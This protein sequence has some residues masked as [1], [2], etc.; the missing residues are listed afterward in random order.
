MEIK[1][2]TDD[3]KIKV[4]KCSKMSLSSLSSSEEQAAA[5]EEI[6]ASIEEIRSMAEELNKI[7]YKL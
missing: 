5:T 4:E 6:T 2:I 3:I 1:K 7:A